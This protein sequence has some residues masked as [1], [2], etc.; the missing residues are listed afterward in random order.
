[1]QAQVQRGAVGKILSSELRVIIKLRKTITLRVPI[2]NGQPKSNWIGVYTCIGCVFRS[3]FRLTNQTPNRMI[4]PPSIA[5]Q[6]MASARI[7]AA[8]RTATGGSR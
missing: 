1:M 2:L 5:G 8:T 4:A 6:V 7:K 3:H